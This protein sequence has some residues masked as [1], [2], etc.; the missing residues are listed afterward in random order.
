M[1][2]RTSEYNAK[3]I[4]S[5][6][7]ELLSGEKK[8]HVFSQIS[9]GFFVQLS[10][11][12]LVFFS[13]EPYRGP[14]TINVSLL[15]GS[16]PVL[17]QE[18]PL[19]ISHDKLWFP[20]EELSIHLGS[21][22]IWYTPQSKGV[23]LPIEKRKSLIRELASAAIQ[24]I[25]PDNTSLI[26]PELFDFADI[27]ANG[28]NQYPEISVEIENI[29]SFLKM[30]DVSSML[31]DLKS[32]LGKGSGLTPSGD[33]FVLGLI[34]ALNR[35]ESKITPGVDQPA[36]NKAITKAAYQA[37]TSLSANL[38]ECAC[39][40]LADERLI[41]A[42]DFLAVGDQSLSKVLSGLRSW[43]NSSGIDALV[44]MMTAMSA[45]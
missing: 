31:R 26:Y 43:G 10:N 42:V 24:Q 41:S 44:G 29:R 25:D 13:Y 11:V 23:P 15:E 17:S 35:W 2:T 27:D 32:F 28:V 37:T 5:Y 9:K 7:Y 14:L 1:K 34:L 12:K 21:A 4:G 30:R 38:I 18:E 33:D 3:V 8:A 22:D 45:G 40:G 20:A 16:L 39:L 6:A 36:I 19:I